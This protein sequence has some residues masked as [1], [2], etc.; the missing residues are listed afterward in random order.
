MLLSVA[1]LLSYHAIGNEKT[2]AVEASDG[3]GGSLDD[4][5]RM[6]WQARTSG[7]LAKTYD[8]EVDKAVGRLSLA[9]YVRRKG[10]IAYKSAKVLGSEIV[11]QDKAIVNVIVE[12]VIPG[13]AGSVATTL[14]DEWVYIDGAWY[15]GSRSEKVDE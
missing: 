15:H 10:R 6:F 14:E 11:G 3:V 5:A 9:Q 8:L 12:A 1:L 7:D 13:I 2:E 4:R